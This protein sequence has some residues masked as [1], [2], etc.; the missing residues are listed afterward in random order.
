MRTLP[1]ALVI[2]LLVAPVGMAQGPLPSATPTYTVSIQNAPAAFTGL[3]TPNATSTATFQVVLSL[4]NVLCTEAAVVPVTIAATASGAPGYFSVRPEPAVINFTI[5][6]G[7]HGSPPVGSPGGGTGDGGVV[8]TIE[9]NITA[10]ASV[11]VTVTATAPA[12]SGCQGAGG[13][14]EATSEPVV[15]FANMTAPPPPPVE[16]PTPEDTPFV[17]VLAVA[18]IA[19]LVALA[20]R[21]KA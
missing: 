10:N 12:P 5:S 7:P 13:I 17:G 15:I 3:D 9:G 18:A 4:T 1:L 2:A 21:R 6:Q 8:A 14:S 11:Q 20:R 19:A 16:E